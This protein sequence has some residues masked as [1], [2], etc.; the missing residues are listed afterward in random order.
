MNDK[1]T[2][3]PAGPGNE[4]KEVDAALEKADQ[5]DASGQN[6]DENPQDGGSWN[7]YRTREMGGSEQ[8][9]SGENFY[10]NRERGNMNEDRG[11]DGGGGSLY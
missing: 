4:M 8:G 10:R 2:N 6:K 5:Q 11:S 7:N 3:Q 9:D 1:K